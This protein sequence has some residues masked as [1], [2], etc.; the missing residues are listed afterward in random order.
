MNN[1]SFYGMR[2]IILMKLKI[3]FKEFQYSIIAP[4]ISSIIFLTILKTVSEYYNLTSSHSDN[5][6][7]FIVP[8]IIIMII[9]QETY[10]N[11]SETL[12]HMKQIGSLN[13][14]L[15]S[16]ISRIEI[17]ISFLIRIWIIGLMIILAFEV[18]FPAENR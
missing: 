1:I 6:M 8:G 7:N 16:P 9:I 13:D 3:F 14:I 2:T 17:A 4:I 12:I 5:F 18:L 11:I 10:A 15:M